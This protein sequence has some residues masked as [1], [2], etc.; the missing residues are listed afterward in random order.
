MPQTKGHSGRKTTYRFD[1]SQ[2][3]VL[4]YYLYVVDVYKIWKNGCCLLSSRSFKSDK[5]LT[6]TNTEKWKKYDGYEIRRGIY[7]EGAPIDF[8]RAHKLPIYQL[9]KPKKRN[10]AK[11]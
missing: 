1:N 3:E 4:P 2:I 7:L 11:R 5:Y 10:E 8:I 9:N 6:V